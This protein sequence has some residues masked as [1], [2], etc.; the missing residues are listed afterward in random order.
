MSVDSEVA[1]SILSP[2]SARCLLACG[3]QLAVAYVLA[4]RL[5][6][7]CSS[8]D[9]WVLVWLCYDA[10]VHFT[11]E[12]PFV[13][14][15]LVGTVATSDNML[16]ELWKEYGKADKRWLYSD[17]TIVSIELLTVI[18]VGLL[19]VILIYSILKNTFYRHFLQIA[20]CVCELYGG[21]MTFCPEWLMGSPSLDTSNWLYFWI[22]LVF[23]NGLWIIIP[24]VLL[25]QS[26]FWFQDTYY[27]QKR[28]GKKFT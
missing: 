3:L 7:R 23:F 26:W 6:A 24:V 18:F 5:G 4:Q 15:S 25:L 9:R 19:A 21:W 8:T 16:A 10:I 12:G 14:M 22:Y 1:A 17:P 11:L 27:L 13:Y 28:P 2:L 20:L